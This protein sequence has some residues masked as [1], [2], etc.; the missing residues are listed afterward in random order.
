LAEPGEF[1]RRAFQQ[2]KIDLTRAEA[3]MDVIRARSDRAL[4]AAQQQLRG[5][6]QVRVQGM[7]D[8]LLDICASIEAYID[9]PEEDLPR[10]DRD[11]RLEEIRALAG[12][13]KK[14]GTTRKRM[15]LLREG[16]GVVLLGEP[17]VGKSSLFN[18]MAG[19][20]RSI[21]SDEPGTTRDFLEERIVVGPHRIRLFDTAGI[22]ESPEG[23]EAAGV[24]KSIATA[25]NADIILLV[26][27]VRTTCPTLSV[28]VRSLMKE[29][30]SLIVMNKCDLRHDSV[31]RDSAWEQQALEVSAIT[32]AGVEKLMDQLARLVEEITKADE[33]DEDLAVN[34][35]HAVAF[36]ETVGHLDR[37]SDLIRGCAPTEL[38]ASELRAAVCTLKSIVGTIDDEQILDRLFARFCI[39]K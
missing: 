39:G 33:R 17:N 22:R 20:D 5:A 36:S 32:G 31:G 2:G 19:F 6:L 3:V 30:P 4:K 18:R 25:G 12:E 34:L 14:L 29:K 1:T 24:A 28:Q 9:F 15:E 38:A 7:A 10:E 35:R 26:V 37:A 8:R 23:V 21:V 27:D 11:A 13:M 16:I